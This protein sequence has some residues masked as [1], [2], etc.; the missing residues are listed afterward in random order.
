MVIRNCST[1]RDGLGYFGPRAKASASKCQDEQIWLGV[2]NY[3]VDCVHCG[4]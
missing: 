3:S 2:V 4:R 1:L